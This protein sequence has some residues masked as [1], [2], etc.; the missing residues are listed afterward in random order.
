[1]ST[2]QIVGIGSA[3][4]DILIRLGEMPTWRADCR[5]REIHCE[6]GGP[7]ATALV[8][9]TRLG[10]TTGYVGTF[11]D[12]DLG[13][14]KR[15]GLE[16]ECVD[17]SH[18]FIRSA[19]ES[20]VVVVLAHQETGERVFVHAGLDD[21]RPVSVQELD[22]EYITSAEYLHL[23]GHHAEAA[24]RAAEWMR[25]AGKTVVLDGYSTDGPV[26]RSL[27]SL[28][29]LTDVLIC[30]SGFGAGVTGERD[31]WHIGEA[32]LQLGPSVVVQTEGEAGSY[33]T[34]R[35]ERFHTPAFKV[36]VVD[37]TGA[38]DVFHGAFIVGLLH[39][40]GLRTVSA[41]SSAVAAIKCTEPG[42]RSGIPSFDT[43]TAFLHSRGVPLDGTE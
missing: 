35:A 32:L 15:R 34:T 30:G 37:T 42:G 43:T 11:G 2:P 16:R 27:C 4:V 13:H 19:A 33:T 5:V 3:T 9:A 7:V 6:G 18:A 17:L 24:L 28:V 38:G 21:R 25:E 14:L 39:R 1:M 36:D 40:W 29:A 22:R 23:D 20:L 12:D 31:V 41:F 10:A 26:D 8:A